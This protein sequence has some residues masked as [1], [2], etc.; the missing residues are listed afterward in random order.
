MSQRTQDALRGRV[1]VVGV[2]T[3]PQGEHPGVDQYRLAIRALRA[4]IADAAIEKSSIDGLLGAKQFDGS[5]IDPLPLAKL[6]GL[7]PRVTGYLD[8]GT[9]GFTTQYAAMLIAT[10]VCETVACVY[11]RNP[12]GVM[13]DLS[14]AITY[15]STYGLFNAAGAAALGWTRHM[16]DY[17]S[18]DEALGHVAVAARKHA[19]LNENAAFR[20]PLSLDDYLAEDYILWPF[21]ELDICKLTAGGVALILTR[22]DRASA[23]PKQPVFMEAIGRQQATRTVED[24][25][26]FMC[27]GMRSAAA[28]VYGAAGLAPADVDVLGMSD[29]S[30]A[31]VLQTLENYGFCAPG[32][33]PEFVADGGIELGGRLPVNTDGG[34]LSGGYLVGWLQQAELVRQLRGECGERQVPGA[35]VG[36]YTGTGRFRQDYIS[37]IYATERS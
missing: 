24:A 20:D 13:H 36:Q 19:R 12:P 31:A 6:I 22:A 4:A 3:T 1:A 9:G 34:Q 26:H 25:G 17:G 21:R 15:D 23:S 11:G 10:G 37:T 2:G 5:G 18:T 35:R 28:Q 14:G 16:H 7:N 8:Y 27:E 29:A 33:S 30:T 32:E